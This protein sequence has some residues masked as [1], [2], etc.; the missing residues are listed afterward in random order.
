MTSLTNGIRREPLPHYLADEP[1][2]TR[3]AVAQTLRNALII[4][5]REVR[6]SLRDWRIMAPIF[7]LTLIFPLLA[8]TMTR[9]FT[10]FFERNG[11]EE[12]LP[13]LL[14]LMPMIV[15][16][17][18]VSISLVIAL[19][20]FV[21]EKERLSLEPLLSTPLTNTELYL[22]KSFAAMLPPLMASYSGMIIYM[23]GLILGDQQWRPAPLLVVQ[24]VLLTTVQALVMVTGAVVVSSQTTSTRAANLLASFII[25]PMSMLVMLEGVIMVQPHRRYLLWYIMLGVLVTIVLLVRMGARIFNREELLGRALDQL[26]LR[27]VFRVFWQQVRGPSTGKFNLWRWY[28]LSVFPA[29]RTLRAPMV[30]VLICITSA[31]IG[32][33]IAADRWTIPLDQFEANDEDLLDNLQY[34]IEMGQDNPQLIVLAVLQNARV[35]LAATIL[36]VFTFGVLALILVSIPFGILGFILAQVVASNLSPLPF[37]LGVIPHAVAEVPAILLAGAAA[38]RLGSVATRPSAGETVGEA[39]LHALA[40]AFKIGVGLVLPLLIVAGILEVMLTPRVI[41]WVLT[42]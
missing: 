22:G 3:A 24:I 10:S 35:L 6:D 21:G 2:G 16:F 18:P 11:A 12:L 4:T 36:A 15:G 32:G 41:E 34:W 40:D 8:N 42:L 17:F 13:A 23:G 29:V 30:V 27:W 1:Q 5:R 28:R 19:E 7:L 9:I 37:F 14:P 31:F 39:W 20:T 33:W 26:N 38:L 25:I